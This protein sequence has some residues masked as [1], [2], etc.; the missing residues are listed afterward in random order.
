MTCMTVCVHVSW[1][2]CCHPFRLFE[3]GICYFTWGLLGLGLPICKRNFPLLFLAIWE[4]SITTAI[5]HLKPDF[6]WFVHVKIFL[7]W[8]ILLAFSFS[9][10]VLFFAYASVSSESPAKYMFFLI[11]IFVFSLHTIFLF[12]WIQMILHR[13]LW[14]NQH[15]DLGYSIYL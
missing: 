4:L 3:L 7:P 2:W 9:L 1:S 6:L 5:T 14:S 8:S 15:T 11:C 10:D 12:S 13:I